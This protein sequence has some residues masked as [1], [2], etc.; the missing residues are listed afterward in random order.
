MNAFLKET[1]M[2]SFFFI[3]RKEVLTDEFG[4]SMLIHRIRNRDSSNGIYS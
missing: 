4:C 3:F 1:Y 2:V